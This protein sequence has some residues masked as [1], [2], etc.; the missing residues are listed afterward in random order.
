MIHALVAAM[1]GIISRICLLYPFSSVFFVLPG[2]KLP[3]YSR[4]YQKNR[5]PTHAK[6]I[7][8]ETA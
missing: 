3:Q 2:P 1:E 4:D 5:T 6:P 7:Y 8:A